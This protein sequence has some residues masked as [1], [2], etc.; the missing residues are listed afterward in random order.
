MPYPQ[1]ITMNQ[2]RLPWTRL[3]PKLY[4]AMASVNAA[5][6]PSSLG[7][8]LIDLVQTRVSQ[9]NGCAFCLDMHVRDLRKHGET[10]LRINSLPTWREVPFYSERER[11]AL[12]WAESLTR[13]V[14]HHGSRDAEY[15]ALAA[16]FSESEIVE[17]S[18]A[19]AQINAWNRLGVGMQLPVADKP[20][21]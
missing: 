3:A 20:L 21:D 12:A 11:A 13:L 5:L 14:E 10:W 9:L 19:I 18:V 7:S 16:H 4:Q 2:A 17:L 15:K 6:A 8:L 1:G